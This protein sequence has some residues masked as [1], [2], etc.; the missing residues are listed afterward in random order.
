MVRT[1]SPVSKINS[2]L[3]IRSAVYL[4]LNHY[5]LGMRERLSE[6]LDSVGGT[7]LQ[8]RKERKCF[9]GSSSQRG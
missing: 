9:Y 1:I 6:D 5:L 3:I 8:C 2:R 7:L 4:L